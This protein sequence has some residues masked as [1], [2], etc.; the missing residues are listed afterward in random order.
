MC[1]AERQRV[2]ATGS[3]CG[4]SVA[5]RAHAHTQALTLE[6]AK[7]A[8]EWMDRSHSAEWIKRDRAQKGKVIG[9]ETEAKKAPKTVEPKRRE[10]KCIELTSSLSS[11]SHLFIPQ[12]M[13]LS[14]YVQLNNF[15]L[16]SQFGWVSYLYRD[17]YN[18]RAASEATK[19]PLVYIA[20]IALKRGYCANLWAL[21]T[22][23]Y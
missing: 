7:D 17:I 9:W 5:T 11:T 22:G 10:K 6:A 18:Q 15:S 20:Y 19:T 2:T 4:G 23:V 8:N 21:S 3:I 14:T 13:Q 1:G 16:R 12:C